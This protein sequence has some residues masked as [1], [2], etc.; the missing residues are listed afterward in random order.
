MKKICCCLSLPLSLNK[1]YTMQYNRFLF[2]RLSQ[3]SLLCDKKLYF[4]SNYMI[5]TVINNTIT[6]KTK[7]FSTVINSNIENVNVKNKINKIEIDNYINQYITY[8]DIELQE[9]KKNN[10][11]ETQY[12]EKAKHYLLCVDDNLTNENE[13]KY[14]L[15]NSLLI[16]YNSFVFENK[17]TSSQSSS[18]LKKNP[19]T[20]NKRLKGNIFRDV[21]ERKKDQEISN[22]LEV[23]TNKKVNL[24]LESIYKDIDI[25]SFANKLNLKLFECLKQKN[26]PIIIY[27]PLKINSNK[28]KENSCEISNDNNFDCLFSMYFILKY[29]LLKEVFILDIQKDVFLDKFNDKQTTISNTNDS[30]RFLYGNKNSRGIK[31]NLFKL[32]CFSS[33]FDENSNGF[34]IDK[35]KYVH[36]LENIEKDGIKTYYDYFHNIENKI[37]IFNYQELLQILNLNSFNGVIDNAAFFSF[38]KYNFNEEISNLLSKLKKENNTYNIV[39]NSL[40]L[41]KKNSYNKSRDNLEFLEKDDTLDLLFDN[42]NML[43]NIRN[44]TLFIFELVILN[45]FDNEDEM[46]IQIKN[47]VVDNSLIKFFQSNSLSYNQKNIILFNTDNKEN[48][49]D[50]KTMFSTF[51]LVNSKLFNDER[52]YIMKPFIDFDKVRSSLINLYY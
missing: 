11:L 47:N 31:F 5:S 39:I 7:N 42:S 13:E 16:D 2:M 50:E 34:K 22:S 4:N 37:I 21:I 8:K 52:A 24:V 25:Y 1:K 40:V 3:Y 49:L 35:E 38:R 30:K 44:N 28:S 48:K 26:E 10:I 46:E 29:I 6:G 12:C 20:Q 36:V 17:L 32:S 9:Y 14:L 19:K 15:P 41:L 33:L 23:K 18:S 45:I 27:S 43:L 51:S